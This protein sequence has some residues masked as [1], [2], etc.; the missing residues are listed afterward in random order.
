MILWKFT[1][2]KIKDLRKLKRFDNFL[3]FISL[4]VKKISQ[5]KVKL[6]H[7][8]KKFLFPPPPDE[9]LL[10]LHKLVPNSDSSI[11]QII[12]WTST[13]TDWLI[14]PHP[15]PSPRQLNYYLV[16]SPQ[17]LINRSLRLKP[18][19]CFADCFFFFFFYPVPHRSRLCSFLQRLRYD[20]LL[21]Y[22]SKLKHHVF[23]F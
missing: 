8:C 20:N 9:W 13:L 16:I 5:P 23:E 11:H 21:I 17:L 10:V 7:S 4:N 1:V 19:W 14:D 6:D 3:F 12:N 22:T 15:P 2:G 18:P